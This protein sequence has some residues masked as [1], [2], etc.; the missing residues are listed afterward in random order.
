MQ[1]SEIA[2]DLSIPVIADLHGHMQDVAPIIQTSTDDSSCLDAPTPDLHVTNS[3][4]LHSDLECTR[5]FEELDSCSDTLPTTGADRRSDEDELRPV[6]L[7][8]HHS[9]ESEILHEPC[10]IETSDQIEPPQH[11]SDPS[12]EPYSSTTANHDSPSDAHLNHTILIIGGPG[13]GKGTICAK[14][15]SDHGFAHLS[16]GELLRAEVA[17]HSTIGLEVES[18]MKAGQLVPDDIV[19]DIVSTRI[20]HSTCSV[21]LDGFPRTVKQA[22]LFHVTPSLVL[23]LDCDDDILI[24]RI[25]ERAKDSG[26]QDDN[27][28]TVTERIKT[29]KAN[30]QPILDYYRQPSHGHLMTVDGSGTIEEVCAQVT[31]AVQDVLNITHETTV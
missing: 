23:F 9:H 27:L 15:V 5:D 21:L 29:F 1:P 28:E 8:P 7:A 12:P 20:S 13:S 16:V 30:A 17:S 24:N 19:M 26:R 11:A 10:I 6:K 18:I 22:E 2:S 4:R 14:L 25:L 31:K 3:E